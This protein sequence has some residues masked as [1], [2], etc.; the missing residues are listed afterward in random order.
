VQINVVLACVNENMFIL[1]GKRMK[2]P[3]PQSQTS[4]Y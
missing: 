1:R 3:A 2:C 4:R